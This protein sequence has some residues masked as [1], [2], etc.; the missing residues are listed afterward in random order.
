[1]DRI[2]LDNS[3]IPLHYQIAD[4][5]MVMLD[6]GDLSADERIPPEEELKGS[7]GVSRTTVRRALDHLL[8]KGLLYRKQGKGTFWTDSARLHRKEKLAGINRQIFS[9]SRET[10]VKVLTK[11]REAAGADV[12]EVLKLAPGSDI[13]VFERIRYINREPMSFTTNYLPVEFGE[14]IEKKHLEKQTMLETLERELKIEL[15]TIEHEVEVT[16]ASSSLSKH[17]GIPALDPVL[18]I[19]TSVYDTEGSPI[20]VVWTHFVESRYKFKV[21]LER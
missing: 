5:L 15:G 9:I 12:A 1:M 16:R 13:T 11:R 6:R 10:T 20:E 2:T 4:Y 18:T 8:R 17:L 3:Q 7:F 19:R 21:I 14:A